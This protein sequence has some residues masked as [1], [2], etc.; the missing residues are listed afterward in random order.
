MAIT[1]SGGGAKQTSSASVQTNQ[2]MSSI[3]MKPQHLLQLFKMNQ[4]GLESSIQKK[5]FQMQR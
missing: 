1:I 2:V 3:D 4:S 5:T